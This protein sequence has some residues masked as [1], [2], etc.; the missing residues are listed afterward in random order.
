LSGLTT[1]HSD[2]FAGRLVPVNEQRI[3][4]VG[5]G[6]IG[7]VIAAM[8][9][10][11]VRRVAVVGSDRAAT[12]LLRDPGLEVERSGTV[13]RVALDA[14]R[15]IDGVSGEFDFCLLAVKASALEQ[16]LPA[17]AQRGGID[18]FVS[19][20]NGLVQDRIAALVGEER[21]IAATVEWGS[22][23]AGGGRVRQ[24]SHSP[25]VIGELDGSVRTRTRSL[26]DALSTVGEVRVTTN[27]RG[28]LWS[29][30]ILNSALS[31]MSVVGGCECSRV[32]ND[33]DGRSALRRL[34]AEGY[35][36]GQ[37]Q[38]LTLEPILGMLAGDAA[39]PDPAVHGPA[40]DVL[41]EKS[42]PTRASML[43]DIER[44]RPTE[45]D[46]INGAVVARADAL[47]AQAPH[48][49]RVLELVHS[50]ERGEREPAPELFAE[51]LAVG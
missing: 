34:W 18:T 45:V 2:T 24:T 48:N 9:Q 42:G 17:L 13:T 35:E 30:L 7:G 5:A 19:L 8:M 47:G 38:Q 39:S 6:A 27:I 46:V 50:F 1:S 25:T 4:V 51:V 43:Q 28:Q 3:L 29:K 11:N 20:G 44:G 22:T 21:L 12:D 33:P 49:Q 14:Y 16:V 32:L 36:L 40:L 10:D 26:A 37:R 23:N 41:L 31:G 15:S